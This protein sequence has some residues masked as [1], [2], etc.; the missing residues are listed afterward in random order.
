[1]ACEECKCFESCNVCGT[2]Y[3]QNPYDLVE[4]PICKLKD[5]LEEKIREVGSTAEEYRRSRPIK[6]AR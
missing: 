4:C 2:V 6:G 3:K 1:M 5:E